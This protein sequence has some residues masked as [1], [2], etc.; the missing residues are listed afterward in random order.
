[1]VSTDFKRNLFNHIALFILVYVETSWGLGQE[2]MKY[3]V[4]RVQTQGQ[5][6]GSGMLPPLWRREDGL[7]KHRLYSYLEGGADHP[8]G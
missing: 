4:R 3:H 7:F 2:E 6:T 1:M 8:A 5:R